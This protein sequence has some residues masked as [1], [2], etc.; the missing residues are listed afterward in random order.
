MVNCIAVVFIGESGDVGRNQHVL[1]LVLICQ[2]QVLG[3][4]QEA[5]AYV[6]GLLLFSVDGVG[7]F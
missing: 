3:R 6:N 4:W 2:A 7:L 5:Y 1:D